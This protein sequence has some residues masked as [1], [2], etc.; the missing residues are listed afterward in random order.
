MV[1][2]TASFSLLAAFL[3]CCGCGHRPAQEK[4]YPVT[5]TVMLDDKPMV[6]GEIFFVSKQKGDFQILPI[7][8]GSFQGQVK[9]GKRR[10]EI[11]AYRTA[12][13]VMLGPGSSEPSRENYLPKR[14]NEESTLTAD[15][16]PDGPN[17]FSFAVASK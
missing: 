2:Q 15:V 16:T 10:V 8:D 17:Q 1:R 13:G 7:K 12:K 11:R 3:A 4:T 6:E 9:V 5:G 14:Y